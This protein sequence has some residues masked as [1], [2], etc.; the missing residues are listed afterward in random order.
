MYFG[1][2]ENSAEGLPAFSLHPFYTVLYRIIQELICFCSTVIAV[3]QGAGFM[4]QY[5][6]YIIPVGVVALIAII[7]F[8]HVRKAVAK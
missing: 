8:A 4:M 1:P 5:F 7:G 2:D 3:H 6:I